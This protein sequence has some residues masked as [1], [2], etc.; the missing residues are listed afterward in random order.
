MRRPLIT[1]L[2]IVLC[3][4]IV[5]LACS[6]SSDSGS[7]NNNPT[8]LDCS[9]VPKTFTSDAAPIFQNSCAISGCHAAGSAN[10][11]GPLTT[12]AQISTSAVAIRAAV[13]SG[14]M[15]KT[16]SLTTAQKNTILCW[17]DN[18]APNN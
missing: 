1:G 12:Y 4:S 11:P 14:R 9:T 8:T 17:I 2:S 18:G 15:P 13:S 5:I 3:S 10:G 16:G 7:N 6:K